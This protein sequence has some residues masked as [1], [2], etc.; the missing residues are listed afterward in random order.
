MAHDSHDNVSADHEYV[1]PP[2]GS[3]H[4]HTDASVGLIVRFAVWLAVSAVVVHVLGWAMFY[5]LV[6]RRTPAAAPEFP[7]AVEQ[8][9]RLPAEPRLQAYPPND[10]T[11][12]RR[13]ER[14][15][16]EGYGWV[17]RDAGTVHIPIA[18][19]MR[20]TVERGL[21]ARAVDDATETPDLMPTDASAGRLMERR[22]Q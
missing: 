6:E 21:P 20:L 7:L 1:N 10:L 11:R 17:D 5:V 4:E 2:S 18:D 13:Q 8:A 9:P 22:R 14:A 15:V 12:F 3:G 19:A 16:L